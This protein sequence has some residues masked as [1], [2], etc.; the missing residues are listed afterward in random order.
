MS[1]ANPQ[2]IA[3]TNAD[4]SRF[5]QNRETMG[6]IHRKAQLALARL[7]CR[8]QDIDDHINTGRNG[9]RFLSYSRHSNLLDLVNCFSTALS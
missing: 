8:P 1:T 7:G 9:Y 6:R 3:Y 4:L 2:R 5:F